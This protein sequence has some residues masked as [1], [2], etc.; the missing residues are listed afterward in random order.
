MAGSI[1]WTENGTPQSIVGGEGL[2]SQVFMLLAVAA[3]RSARSPAERAVAAWFAWHDIS[4]YGR[5]VE[6]IALEEIPWTGT[7]EEKRGFLVRVVESLAGARWIDLF[8]LSPKVADVEGVLGRLR[9]ALDVFDAAGERP[10]EETGPARRYGRCL[11][12]GVP[13]HRYGCIVCNQDELFGA[14]SRE[15]ARLGGEL[16][17]ATEPAERSE[18]A[19]RL[20]AEAKQEPSRIT[21]CALAHIHALA[22]EREPPG[23]LRTYLIATIGVCARTAGEAL[24]LRHVAPLAGLLSVLDGWDAAQA[25]SILDALEREEPAASLGDT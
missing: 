25:H 10:E 16:L 2:M 3:A 23:L 14:L 17:T 5:E 6:T 24:Q 15:Q 1:T 13:M 8:E 20:A 7:P 22:V 4:V 18:A 19:R 11:L 12:H 21:L 9:A